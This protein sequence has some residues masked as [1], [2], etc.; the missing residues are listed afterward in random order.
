MSGSAAVTAGKALLKLSC[1]T[2]ATCAGT[3][4][5]IVKIKHGRKTKTV[6]IGQVSYSVVA[7]RSKVLKIKL[8]ALPT[9]CPGRARRYTQEQAPQA[10]I[11]PSH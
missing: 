5:L 9:S 8:Q 10:S 6:V 2:A 3:L 4:K 1:S 7:G 11:T